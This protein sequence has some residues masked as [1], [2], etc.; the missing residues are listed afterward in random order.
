MDRTRCRGHPL[1]GHPLNDW[2]W[3]RGSSAEAYISCRP[4]DMRCQPLYRPPAHPARERGAYWLNAP[5]SITSS[6]FRIMR[7]TWVASMNCCRLPMSVSNTF[8]SF[9]SYVPLRLQSMPRGHSLDGL[10][11]RVLGQRARR[12][13]QRVGKCPHGVLLDGAA[14]VGLLGNLDRARNLGR[15]PAVHD[16]VVADQ[17]AHHADGVVERALGFVQDHLVAAAAEYGHRAGSKCLLVHVPG[18]A[19]LVGGQLGEARDNAGVARDG[20]E[21]ELHPTHPPD[22]RQAS[23]HQQV[24]GLVVESPLADDEI[25]ARVLHLL[26]HVDEV[27]LL[28]DLHV[29][30]GGHRLQLQLVLRLG[31]GRLE[32]AGEHADLGVLD[33]LGHLRMRHVLVD[34]DAA[35]QLGVL[36][37]AADLAVHLDQIQVD[38]FPLKIGHGH[39]RVHRDLAHL[40]VGAVD[41]LGAECGHRNL[42]QGFLVGKRVFKGVGDG[43]QVLGGDERGPVEPLGHAHWVDPSVEQCLG[44]L[45]QRAGQHNHAGGA[46]ANLIVLRLGELHQQLADLVLDL[47]LLQD[48]GPVVGDGHVAVGRLEH[49]VHALW[50]QRRLEDVADRLGGKDV[51]LLRLKALHTALGVA[52][53]DDDEGPAILVERQ[54]ARDW[55]RK[56][57]RAREHSASRWPGRPSVS[58]VEELA[59]PRSGR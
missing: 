6:I 29:L 45:E 25:G 23:L 53:L 22:R 10:Q 7:T 55:G 20:D 11:A 42:N 43:V 2:T 51:G 52:F 34:H 12:L 3:R 35:H 4:R 5:G 17:V 50:A 37:R 31:L 14:L 44:L 19:Q 59:P 56:E 28:L 49:L 27:L 38:V 1:R 24:V 58:G 39:H 18:A 57:R 13:L 26:D 41:D 46:V 32:R 47:H 30:K 15:A 36:E 48:S 8:C 54:A 33:V 40:A 16:P 21:L 9:M